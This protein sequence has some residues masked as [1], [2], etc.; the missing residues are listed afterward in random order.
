MR[1]SLTLLGAAVFALGIQGCANTVKYGEATRSETIKA[2]IG[3]SELQMAT[4]RLVSRML[5]Y[6]SVEQRTSNKRPTVA[7][8]PI[9]NHTHD[10]MDTAPLTASVFQELT[11]AG[12]FRFS[13]PEKVRA[14]REQASN[15]LDYG[16][17]TEKAAQKIGKQVDADMVVYGSLVDIIRIKPTHK[18]VY[19]RINLNLLDTSS[20]E[21]IWHDEHEILKSQR[22][23]I[24]GI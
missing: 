11:N 5:E 12:K 20:G 21:V 23:A 16:A 7:I 10:A 13:S 4:Q 6:P 2:E 22:K 18:E 3:M 17:T 8:D 24:Y 9:T 19:Y 1:K 14:S 15:L